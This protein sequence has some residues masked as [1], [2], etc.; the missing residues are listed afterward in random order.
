[1]GR[2]EAGLTGQ[3]FHTRDGSQLVVVRSTQGRGE[4]LTALHR[5]GESSGLI[6]ESFALFT[7]NQQELRGN[8]TDIDTRAT[9]HRSTL[10]DED[11]RFAVLSQVGSQCLTCLPKANN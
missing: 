4:L 3:N 7:F 9:V 8:T 11:N 2:E 6:G 1:M 10:L 5:S